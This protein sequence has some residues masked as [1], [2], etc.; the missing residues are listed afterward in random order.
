MPLV[1]GTRLGAYEILAPLGAGGMAEVYRAR[2]TTLGR[3][4][5]LKLL[6]AGMASDPD[7]LARFEHE[8]RTV[9]G[10]SHPNIVVLHSMDRDGDTHFLTMELV[11][12]RSLDTYVAADLPLPRVLELGIELADALT[13]AHEQG[14]IH[15]DLKP[16]NVMLTRDGRVKVL[17][18]GLAKLARPE[19]PPDISAAATVAAPITRVGQV[20]GTLPYMAPEQVRGEG[21]DARSDVFS[22]AVVLYE[23]VANRR[24]FTGETSADLTSAILRDKPTPLGELR[25]DLPNDLERIVS[26]CLEKDPNE[27]IQTARDVSNEL[28]RLRNSLQGRDAAP[29]TPGRDPAAAAEPWAPTRAALAVLPFDN[30]TR[31]PQQEYFAEGMVEEIVTGLS[32]IKWLF[33]ISRNS[34]SIYKDRPIEVTAIGRELGVRYLL[35]GSVRRSGDHVRVTGRLIDAPTGALVWA[36]RYEA[37]WGDIFSLQDEMTMSVIGAVEPTLRKA[38]VERVRRKRP[39]SL[40]AYELFLRALPLATT[41][42]PEDADM[43][44]RFLDEAIRLEPDYAAAHG[45]LA[46]CHEQ[47]YL[48]GGLHADTRQNALM[49]ARAAIAAGA[50]DAWRWGWEAS[51]S[52]FSKRI[53]RPRSRRLTARSPSARP[54]LSPSDSARSSGP[55]AGISRWPSRMPVRG[56]GS[57]RW[58]R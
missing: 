46:W 14:V 35:Q 7:R 48:R 51:S 6:P 5:A 50:D 52:G 11:E 41:A 54:R 30:L 8:A 19:P 28:R 24:P 16:T 20:V 9:A 26:R 42:M 56:F 49:H 15:R 47:R 53:S 4:V 38:E 10:L 22:L 55:T 3:D 23:L 12:G 40:D 33:V 31:D 25:P 13:A 21:A 29:G 37:P 17:D 45:I 43:A 32:R 1:A 27:R 34:T 58:I 18:F 2:D 36:D 57:A 44:L 39:D